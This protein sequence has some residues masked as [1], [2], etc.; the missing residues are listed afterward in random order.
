MIS[1][2]YNSDKF[3][4]K[5]GKRKNKSYNQIS[6]KEQFFLNKIYLD[7]KDY[8]QIYHNLPAGEKRNKYLN[9]YFK[10]I[11][12]V[13]KEY[14]RLNKQFDKNKNKKYLTYKDY[15]KIN[16]LPKGNLKNKY[17]QKY[18]DKNPLHISEYNKLISKL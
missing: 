11:P 6:R 17:L 10:K 2:I 14:A 3:Y 18:F 5:N 12:L 7:Y 4:Y 8:L 9:K 1:K 16:N 13:K 15:L